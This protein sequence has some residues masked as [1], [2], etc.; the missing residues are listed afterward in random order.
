MTALNLIVFTCLCNE[1]EEAEGCRHA[2]MEGRGQVFPLLPLL[3]SI[4][5]RLVQQAL[6]LLSYLSGPEH[7]RFLR[8]NVKCSPKK[9]ERKWGLR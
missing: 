8:V 5:V 1:R 3:G 6:Y 7:A 9:K 4:Q 2:S